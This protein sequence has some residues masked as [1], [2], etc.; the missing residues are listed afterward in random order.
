MVKNGYLIPKDNK[1]IG[2]ISNIL[3]NNTDL[4]SEVYNSVKV[5]IQWDTSIYSNQKN[6][7]HNLC[8]I[9]CSALPVS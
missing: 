7:N 3:E 5:G 8:Q 4:Y 1:C 6:T 2:I 9:Y